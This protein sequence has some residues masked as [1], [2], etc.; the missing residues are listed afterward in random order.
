M[1]GIGEYPTDIRMCSLEPI[2]AEDFHT[3]KD[4][5]ILWQ[6]SAMTGWFH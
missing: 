3:Q 6:Q 1:H 2:L 4:E 5:A